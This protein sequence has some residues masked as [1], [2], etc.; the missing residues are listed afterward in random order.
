MRMYG[1]K[2][3]VQALSEPLD[4][5]GIKIA[6]PTDRA[7]ADQSVKNHRLPQ[8]STKIEYKIPKPSSGVKYHK[9]ILRNFELLKVAPSKQNLNT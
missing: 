6:Q 3:H 4:L 2:L 9:V 8:N 5:S 7:V 1:A